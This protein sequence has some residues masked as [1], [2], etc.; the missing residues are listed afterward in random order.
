MS[1]RKNVTAFFLCFLLCASGCSFSQPQTDEPQTEAQTLPAGTGLK[2][3]SQVRAALHSQPSSLSGHIIDTVPAGV[4]LEIVSSGGE[5]TQ[6]IYGDKSGYIYSTF[7]S[8]NAQQPE[9]ITIG[10]IHTVTNTKL[11][12]IAALYDGTALGYGANGSRVDDHNRDQNALD[13]ETRLADF[14]P[15]VFGSKDSNTIYLSFSCGW[16][17]KPNTATILDT[18]AA[19]GVKAVFYINYEYASGNPDLVRRM[20]NEGHEVGNHGYSHPDNGMPS[21][22]LEEQMN[23]AIRMQA[24][25]YDNFGYTMRKY[26]FSSSAWSYQSVALMTAMGYQVC[27]YSFN[28]ADYD[29]SQPKDPAE[30]LTMFTDA[31][32][33]GC[34]YYLHPVSTGNTAAL[35]PFIQAA[36]DRGYKFGTLP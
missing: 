32:S 9:L 36:R 4:S 1:F 35:E 26:N 20:I 15:I 14:H 22:S 5:W 7:L 19:A 31:L 21:L 6:V 27:F 17:N 23:D 13:L 16:E 10:S 33:P 25:M 34:I 3:A 12:E 2:T 28:Y 30:V 11:N 29:V 18:L 8:E 24:Y